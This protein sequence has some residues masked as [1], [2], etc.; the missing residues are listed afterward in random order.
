MLFGD[1]VSYYFAVSFLCQGVFFFFDVFFQVC[2]C[3]VFQSRGGFEFAL[4]LGFFEAVICL[5]EL[6][7]Q[8]FDVVDISYFAFTAGGQFPVASLEVCELL[9]C[10]CEVF[11]ACL[12]G[13]FFEGFSFDFELDDFSS[14]AV[15]FGG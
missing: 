6:L 3:F 15:E 13:F 2:D 4:S 14:D 9:F 5:F 11:G 12:V 10:V 8:V 7:F 1:F